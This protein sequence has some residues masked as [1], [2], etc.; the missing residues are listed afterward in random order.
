MSNQ[1][2][3]MFYSLSQDVASK[4]DTTHQFII[5][6]HLPITKLQDILSTHQ[7]AMTTLATSISFYRT[8]TLGSLV[9]TFLSGFSAGASSSSD[10]SP[11][12]ALSAIAGIVFIVSG[13]LWIKNSSNY[14]HHQALSNSYTQLIDVKK[15][16]ANS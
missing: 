6:S 16:A 9:V 11:L 13:I 4:I 14:S 15:L 2:F 8:L 5:N 12:L 7:T 10:K 1:A 3:L